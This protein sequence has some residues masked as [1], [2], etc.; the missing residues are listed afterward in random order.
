ME[1]ER[2]LCARLR[3]VD[4]ACLAQH[5]M[6]MHAA[7]TS[8]DEGSHLVELSKAMTYILRH[9]PPPGGI[10]AR[11]IASCCRD[12]V[13]D[14][15]GQSRMGAGIAAGASFGHVSERIA[16]H[17]SA[18]LQG[19]RSRCATVGHQHHPQGRFVVDAGIDAVRIRAAQGHSFPLED[20]LLRPV[21]SARLID[22]A[23]HATSPEAYACCSSCIHAMATSQMGCD[24]GNRRAASNAVRVPPPSL[25]ST[26]APTG[27]PMC[28][29]PSSRVTCAAATGP[30]CFWHWTW[31]ARWR[32]ATRCAWPPTASSSLRGPFR[33]PWCIACQVH[34]QSGTWTWG[35]AHSVAVREYQHSFDERST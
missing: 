32:R 23:V 19:M 5:D 6:R 13:Y 7:P 33:C 12:T 20:P 8:K 10:A 34:L 27:E 29:L 17:R 16:L 30:P 11:T 35:A 1:T 24:P 9:Q 14:R 25:L 21:T 15:H 4:D 18:G 22:W 2:A 26:Q 31:S 3:L 28:T